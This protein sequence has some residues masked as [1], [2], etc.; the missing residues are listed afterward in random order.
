MIRF[1]AA[2]L[3][4]AAAATPVLAADGAEVF[5]AQCRMCHSGPSTSL[6]PSL[7]GVAGAKIAGR[8]DFSYSPALKAK[9]GTWTDDNLNAL[10]KGPAD[11]A[12]GTRMFVSPP[13]SDENRG[14]VIEYLKTLKA[15]PPPP[16]AG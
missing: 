4:A 6:A 3:L 15:P 14:A 16:P 7:D 1:A 11:F 13:L 9:D 8:D 2:L 5:A 10:L 12:P